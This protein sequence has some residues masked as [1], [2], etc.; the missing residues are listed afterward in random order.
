MLT[1][2]DGSKIH[3]ELYQE[4]RKRLGEKDA[5]KKFENPFSYYGEESRANVS[6]WLL[7]IQDEVIATVI[8]KKQTYIIS[9]VEEDVYFLKYPVS[10]GIVDSSYKM[11]AVL[12]SAWI[13]KMFKYSF[14]LGMGGSNSKAAKFFRSSRFVNVDIPFYLQVTSWRSLILHNPISSK[15]FSLKNNLP[16]LKYQEDNQSGLHL[17]QVREFSYAYNYW[18]QSSFSLKRTNDLINAQSLSNNL[19]FLKYDIKLNDSSIGGIII[20]ETAPRDHKLFGNLNIWTILELEFNPKI[21]SNFL[22]NKELRKH[23]IKR[24]IDVVLI[25]SGAKLHKEFCKQ[26]SWI[27]LRSNF[28]LSMSPKLASKING[29]D[30]YITRIDGDGPINLGSNL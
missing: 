6:L 2:Y 3:I 5:D 7:I 18:R 15:Y 19:P 23:A 11:A 25:N 4:F 16:K 21:A 13:K 24:N 20:F 17:K 28:C 9:G 27:N 22:I 14:L 30:I 10:L 26:L 8:T 12:L 29:D 1:Q